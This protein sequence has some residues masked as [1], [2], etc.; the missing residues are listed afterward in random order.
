MRMTEATDEI[1]VF[2]HPFVADRSPW[3]NVSHH[4]SLLALATDAD[5]VTDH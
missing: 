3:S 2:F 4:C 5:A 1:N